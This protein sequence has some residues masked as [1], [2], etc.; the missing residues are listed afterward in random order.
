MKKSK[1]EVENPI[2]NNGVK[3]DV[4]GT[5]IVRKATY[6]IEYIVKADGTTQL[7]RKADRF[8]PFELLGLLDLTRGEIIAQMQGKIKPDIIKREVVRE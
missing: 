6:T 3:G 4:S 1:K 7:N 2:E 5:A 8:S